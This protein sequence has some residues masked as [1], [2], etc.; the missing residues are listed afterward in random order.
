MAPGLTVNNNTLYQSASNAFMR[1]VYIN[2]MGDPTLRHDP[3]A[4]RPALS[5]TAGPTASL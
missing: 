5:A 2:L 1:A 4:R 3:I